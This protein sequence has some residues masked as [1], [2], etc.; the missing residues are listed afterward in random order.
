MR[1]SMVHS[2]AKWVDL[3]T[4]DMDDDL[5]RIS[6]TEGVEALADSIRSVG[7]VNLP[8]LEEKEPNRFRIVCGFKRLLACRRIGM[9]TVQCRVV[10][11]D[12]SPMTC[13][14]IAIADN[15]MGPNPP[16]I[17]DQARAVEK[18]RSLCAPGDDLSLIA[19]R[20][21]LHVDPSLV[22]KYHRLCSLPAYLQKLVEDDGVSMAMAIELGA[23][24]DRDAIALSG[25]FE[26]LRPTA[27][28]Q[29][30]LLSALKAISVMHDTDMTAILESPDLSDIIENDAFDRKQKIQRLRQA[31]RKL[32]YPFI[33]RFESHFKQQIQR[34]ALPKGMALI[35]PRDFESPSYTFTIEF[36]NAIELRH[37]AKTLASL[38]EN[39]ALKSI[40]R[41]DIENT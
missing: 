3:N 39:S 38:S 35:A 41:R 5:Y 13:L 28:H 6:R 7:L 15:T 16:G 37:H 20:L 17:L 34:M 11:S 21:G 25:L 9:E 30:E 40:L 1:T 2:G 23:M 33:S 8:L 4:V 14:S 29:K 10:S 18:I 36:S 27:S 22:E 32:R 24:E 31:V 19:G 26:V 12:C